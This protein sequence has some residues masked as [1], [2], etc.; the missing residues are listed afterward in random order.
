MH[1]QKC[2]NTAR[3]EREGEQDERDEGEGESEGHPV[4]PRRCRRVEVVYRVLHI[5]SVAPNRT[6]IYL[7]RVRRSAFFPPLV[8]RVVRVSCVTRTHG[9]Q[10]EK[11]TQYD[12]S[13]KKAILL[14]EYVGNSC[15][16]RRLG[17]NKSTIRGWRKNRDGIFHAAPTRKAFRGPKSGRYPD[18][19]KGLAEFVQE[20]RGQFLPVN[21]ET[22]QLKVRKLA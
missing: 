10:M 3:E 11:R 6:R 17:V 1:T 7:F 12:A 20:R 14:F 9:P 15:A 16:A 18:L 4:A 5:V 22:I 21:A 19:E 8:S 13:F 2:K